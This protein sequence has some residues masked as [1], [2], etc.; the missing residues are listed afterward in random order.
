MKGASLKF[1]FYLSLAAYST[2]SLADSL[3]TKLLKI[4]DGD[5]IVV[6]FE[7]AESRFQLSGIDAPE[8]IDN[9]KLKF[10]I[11]TTGLD[12]ETLLVIG[13][14]ATEHLRS[15]LPPSSTV[16]I[17]ANMEQQDKYGRIPAIVSNSNGV[18]VNEAMVHDGYAVL[19]TSYP[20]D[21]DFKKRLQRQQIDAKKS[22]RGLWGKYPETARVWFKE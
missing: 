13:D 11:K 20:L 7:G 1:I 3:S 8:N 5:T 6:D 10:D 21:A 12:A 4:E 15:L 17:S 2:G 14:A 22:N 19:L 18:Q 16:M 9:A